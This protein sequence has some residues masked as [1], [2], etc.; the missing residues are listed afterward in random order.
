MKEKINKRI[1]TLQ[2]ENTNLIK[3]FW[4]PDIN[5]NLIIEKNTPFEKK[6]FFNKIII[7]ELNNLIT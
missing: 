4:K 5:N 2:N 7:Q 3:L 6:I 1:Q